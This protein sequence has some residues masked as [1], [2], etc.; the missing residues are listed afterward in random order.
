MR[1]ELARLEAAEGGLPE[2]DRAEDIPIGTV[3]EIQSQG[4]CPIPYLT[5]GSSTSGTS[6][7]QAVF[8]CIQLHTP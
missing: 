5:S 7:H 4:R 6:T 1:P 8:M 2:E 3:E